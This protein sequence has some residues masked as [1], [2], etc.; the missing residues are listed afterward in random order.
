[1]KFSDNKKGEPDDERCS[2]MMHWVFYLI[3]CVVKS[4]VDRDKDYDLFE[5]HVVRNKSL[6]RTVKS[7]A[8]I[9]GKYHQ[10][11]KNN[12]AYIF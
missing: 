8:K 4:E 5:V 9:V 11:E 1:M 12:T 7:W 10:E 2:N 6:N 3:C